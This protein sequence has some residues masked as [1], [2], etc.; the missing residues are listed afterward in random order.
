VVR[1]TLG[2]STAAEQNRTEHDDAGM[3]TACL[4]EGELLAGGLGDRL[5]LFDELVESHVDDVLQ[6][7]LVGRVDG[8]SDDGRYLQRSQ[9]SPKKYRTFDRT[10]TR[11]RAHTH[12]R[13][14]ALCPA[15]PRSAGTRKVKPIRILLKQETVS[16]SG[17]SWAI[18]KSAHR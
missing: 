12:T 1:P 18:G 16:G 2:S 15:L 7:G 17:I 13:S 11:A 5:E 10:H 4:F 14:M 9:H 8:A 6:G 3:K